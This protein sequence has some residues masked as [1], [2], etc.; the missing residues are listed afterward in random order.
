MR[1]P[2]AYALLVKSLGIIDEMP[3]KEFTDAEMDVIDAVLKSLHP[4]DTQNISAYKIASRY[5][6]LIGDRQNVKEVASIFG[7]KY[8]VISGHVAKIRTGLKG[9]A[10][11]IIIGTM[12]EHGF[13]NRLPFL[14]KIA[15]KPVLQLIDDQVA[16]LEHRISVLQQEML[17]KKDVATKYTTL[18]D[19]RINKRFKGVK[20]DKKTD[21]GAFRG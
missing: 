12:L 16:E 17:F 10:N 9:E 5:F 3:K 19:E 7:V 1:N 6:G 15:M 4:L 21:N 2:F 18:L 13:R 8:A 20:D 14:N 11:K